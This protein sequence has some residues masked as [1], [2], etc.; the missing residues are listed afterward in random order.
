MNGGVGVKACYGNKFIEAKCDGTWTG[1][2][3]MQFAITFLQGL[4]A[5]RKRERA[6][7]SDVLNIRDGLVRNW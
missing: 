1:F 5:T 2:Y 7:V 6:G 3:T 4:V